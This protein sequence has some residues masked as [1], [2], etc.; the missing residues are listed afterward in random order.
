MAPE[1]EDHQATVEAPVVVGA[2]TLSW[3]DRQDANAVAVGHLRY[4][5]R[6]Y[7]NAIGNAGFMAS[8]VQHQ[9]HVARRAAGDFIGASRAILR[10]LDSSLS[11][12]RD[13]GT[14]REPPQIMEE[15][16]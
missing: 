1:K 12:E 13:G 6:A 2:V 11:R 9:F 5:L 10:D 8:G 16:K 3:P 15:G 7:D 14:G 4:A